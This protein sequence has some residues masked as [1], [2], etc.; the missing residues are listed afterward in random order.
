VVAG[1]SKKFRPQSRIGKKPVEVP[2]GVQVTLED[3]HLTVKASLP[4]HVVQ[5]QLSDGVTQVQADSRSG[6][7][8]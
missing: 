4:S 5:Q 1:A 2:K 3:N 8:L 7:C 6:T